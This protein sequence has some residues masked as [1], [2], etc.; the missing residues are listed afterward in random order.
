MALTRAQADRPLASNIRLDN[1]SDGPGILPFKLGLTKIISHDHTFL[2]EINLDIIQRQID[3]MHAQLTDAANKIPNQN[4]LLFKYQ[5][6]HLFSKLNKTTL[7]LE[8]FEPRR[9]KRGLFNPLGTFI[10]SISGNLDNDDALQFENALKILQKNDQELTFNLNRH[11]SLYKEM[12]IQ[13]TS[14]LNNMSQNQQ[15]LD[16]AISHIIN[17]TNTDRERI[18][19]YAQLSQLFNMISE[20]VQDLSDEISRLENI[21]AFSRTNSMHHSL[22]SIQDLS[23]MI[24]K[25]K[26][27][28]GSNSVLNL[29]IRYY[30]DLVSLGSYFADKKIVIVLKFPILS[31]STYDLYRLC[32]VPNKHSEIILPSF[33]YL[34]TNSREFVYMEAECPKID[35]WYICKQ[36]ISHQTRTQRDCIYHLIYQ[37]E[38]DDTCHPTPISLFK[39][40][41]LELDSQHYVI[42]FPKQTKVQISCGQEEH[43]LLQGSY[44]AT[45]P[46]NCSIKTPEFTIA[47]IDDKIRGHAVEIMTIP[48][49]SSITKKQSLRY[50]LTT[51]DLNKLHNI[52]HQVLMEVPTMVDSL[53]LSNTPI[54]HTTIPLYGVIVF[55]T[56][57]LIIWYYYRQQRSEKWNPSTST[58]IEMS[59]LSERS[60]P[61]SS[62]SIQERKAATF[63][64]N[65]S[66]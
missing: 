63:A 26:A 21:L 59:G 55:S 28:Y 15:K 22:L 2:Q 45:I 46:R 51:I 14:I 39:E 8:T 11:I 16:K 13:Q 25:L 5:I 6:L 1:L 35:T 48:K 29:D 62:T 40:A 44:L 56:A 23:F 7:Q 64:L 53:N 9:V 20:N 58:N 17:M 24:S 54:Y 66:K 4:F 65:I 27:F 32:P 49:E 19:Q 41:L 52:Q 43:H 61:G 12:T 34:A 37:Q 30:Y 60:P 10:K 57:A 50:N 38:I 47:N 3:L 36:K 33:P 42:S 18:S 31:M